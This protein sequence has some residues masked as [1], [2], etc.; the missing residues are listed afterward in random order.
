M[1][2]TQVCVSMQS[3]FFMLRSPQSQALAGAAKCMSD[4][5]GIAYGELDLLRLSTVPSVKVFLGGYMLLAESGL[6]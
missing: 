3:R 6:F 5:H 1:S 2:A 4:A